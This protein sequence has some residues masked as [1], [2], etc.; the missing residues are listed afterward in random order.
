METTTTTPI[1]RRRYRCGHCREEGH[2][3][4]TCP[5]LS[6][7]REQARLQRIARRVEPLKRIEMLNYNEYPVTV[8]WTNDLVAP[9]ESAPLR[10]LSMI[11]GFSPSSLRFN[12][13]HRIIIVPF[14]E[15]IQDI[16]NND[17]QTYLRTNTI[18]II[19]DVCVKDII[20]EN[21]I[22]S[23]VIDKIDYKPP[24]TELEQWKE[25]AFKATYLLSELEKMGAGKYDNLA[26]MMDMV[27]DI[28]IPPHTQHDR[29]A[30]GV[31]SVLTNIT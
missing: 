12:K 10:Y 31:P 1:Q 5:G 20:T 13:N 30:A 7:Q 11:R 16:P 24:K 26:P 3:R 9:K 25:T 4:S 14:T 23:I 8:L 28:N 19:L 17:L 2:N 18:P 27:Q 21:S 15:A 6:E 29:E 22:I